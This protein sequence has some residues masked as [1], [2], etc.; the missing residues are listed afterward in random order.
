MILTV[1][2]S[3]QKAVSLSRA[4]IASTSI[5]SSWIA[6]GERVWIRSR[7]AAAC[8]PYTAGPIVH[9]WGPAAL[10]PLI[11]QWA[12]DAGLA[13]LYHEMGEADETYVRTWDL[14]PTIAALSRARAVVCCS[15][16]VARCLRSVYKYEGR[17]A[18]IPFMVEEAR[19]LPPPV[20]RPLTIGAIG[21]L[22]PHKRFPDLIHAVQRLQSEGVDTRLI[23]AGSGPERETLEHLCRSLGVEHR[24]DFLGPFTHVSEVMA[25]FDVFA[26]TSSSESQCMPI[27]ESMAY[28]K[29]AVVSAIGGM[30]D[31]V[32]DGVTGYVVPLGD[33][34]R[35]VEALRRFN[36]DPTLAPRMGSAARSKFLLQYRPDTV[37]SAVTRLY[38]DLTADP[39]ALRQRSAIPCE[40]SS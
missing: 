16:S 21:R 7:L 33:P 1:P 4:W 36:E 38:S 3:L 10:T 9:V 26:L 34:D 30:P 23:I 28:G 5:A 19:E 39:Q 29:P 31:F 22:V 32:E 35:L 25:R 40:S 12:C 18:S 13:A 27:T 17:V 37:T 2:Y 11:L 15:E 20:P 8:R 6:R 14:A 24:V